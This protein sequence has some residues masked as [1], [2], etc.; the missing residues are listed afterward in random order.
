MLTRKFPFWVAVKP[1]KRPP[2]AQVPSVPGR[3]VPAF[4]SLESAQSFIRQA[5]DWACELRLV[6]RATFSGLVKRLRKH[7]FV[8]VCFDPG[9]RGGG[10]VLRFQE[11]ASPASPSPSSPSPSAECKLDRSRTS[12]S[13]VDSP[14]IAS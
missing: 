6:C 13:H 3:Y 8:G 9:W 11:L 1:R 10:A 5:N 7:G 12:E 14:S 2:V 4:T